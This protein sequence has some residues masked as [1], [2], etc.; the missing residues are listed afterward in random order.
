MRRS[1]SLLAMA[2]FRIGSVHAVEPALESSA[3]A[4]RREPQALPVPQ[5]RPPQAAVGNGK[6]R[7]EVRVSDVTLAK[8]LERWAQQAGYRL[9]WDAARNFLVGA[10]DS[11]DGS[12]DDAMA[13][14]LGSAGIR[15]SDYP[16][17]VCIYA[18][19]PPL[20]RVTRAGEQSLECVADAR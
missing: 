8:T 12:I 15:Q 7:W 14:V 4:Y 9:R 5:Y 3:D 20:I 13:K 17:E 18:N 11:F 10:P 16:L 19:T 1:I 6:T 2:L